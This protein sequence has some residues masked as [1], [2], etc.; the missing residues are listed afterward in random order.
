MTPWDAFQR[1]EDSEALDKVLL[2]QVAF[3]ALT[4]IF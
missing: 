4:K 1:A 3:E 2:E